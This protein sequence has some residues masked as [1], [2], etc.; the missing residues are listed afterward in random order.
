MGEKNNQNFIE[1]PHKVMIEM[2]QYKANLA[3]I[4]V[5]RTN[6]SYTSQNSALDDETP[7][8]ENGNSSRKKQDKRPINRRIKRGLVKTNNGT[9]DNADINGAMQ[10]IR[11]VFSKASFVKGIADVVL[12]PVK[13]TVFI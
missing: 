2:I 7:C 13:W 12:R 5:T 1:I 6:E 10:I 4:S 9:L 8:W 3:G 11:K